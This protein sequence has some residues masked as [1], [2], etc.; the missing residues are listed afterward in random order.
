MGEG[1]YRF[2]ITHVGLVVMVTT[3]EKTFSR[4]GDDV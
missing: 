1:S 2:V 4:H 3:C